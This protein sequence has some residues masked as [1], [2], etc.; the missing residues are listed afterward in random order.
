MPKNPWLAALLSLVMAGLGQ[1][2]SGA[3][4]RGI[5]FLA[6]DL[7]T[8]YIYLYVNGSIGLILNT[9]VTLYSVIDAYR[10]ARLVV[11][12]QHE[13]KEEMTVVRVF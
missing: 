1:I 11:P 13:E 8:V 10:I 12:E 3:L 6:S 9:L 2:Y 7:L 4:V 5:V